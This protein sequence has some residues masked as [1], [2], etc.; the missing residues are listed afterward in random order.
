MRR[1]ST[2]IALLLLIVVGISAVTLA[3]M[4][5]NQDRKF[6]TFISDLNLLTNEIV[7][8]INSNPTSTG[9]VEAQKILG[10]KK[11]DLKKNLAE[12]KTVSGSQVSGEMLVRFQ[13]SLRDN[14][15]K[16]SNL[17]VENPAVMKALKEDPQFLVDMKNLMDDYKSII[18]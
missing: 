12:L 7:K 17:L 5:Y 9:V 13:E 11:V 8:E 14:R 16:I 10:A 6:A 18:K 4:S 15:A 2:K 3:L 1:K